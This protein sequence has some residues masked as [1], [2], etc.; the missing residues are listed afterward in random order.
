[1]NSN[2]GSFSLI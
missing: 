1:M 2:L